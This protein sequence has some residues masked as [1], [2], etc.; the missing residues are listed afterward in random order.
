MT[1]RDESHA[2]SGSRGRWSESG[3]PHSGWSCVDVDDIGAPDEICGMC[4]SQPVRYIHVMR[5]PYRSETIRAGCIC[6]GHMQGDLAKAAAR[7]KTMRSRSS[8]KKHWL[9]RKEWHIS[10]R[11]NWTITVDDY[12]VT[13]FSRTEGV[14]WKVAA[15]KVGRDPIFSARSVATIDEAKFAGFDLVS[16]LLLEDP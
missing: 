7:D 3:L 11:G 9:R 14:S 2:V 4:L 5:H 8:K 1:N 6:A 12:R 13:V 16:R 15:G 10:A